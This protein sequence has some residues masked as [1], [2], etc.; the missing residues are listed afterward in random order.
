MG[1][2][3][4]LQVIATEP[5]SEHFKFYGEPTLKK[6]VETFAAHEGLT[7]SEACRSLILS[8]VAIQHELSILSERKE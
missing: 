1:I 2:Q 5:R 7:F 8:T 4:A 6:A 3:Q